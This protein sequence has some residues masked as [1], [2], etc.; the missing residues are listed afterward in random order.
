MTMKVKL[1]KFR[2]LILK[3]YK[4][5]AG[6]TAGMMGLYFLIYRKVY[7]LYYTVDKS[8]DTTRRL[9]L[10]FL[11]EPAE[12]A[13]KAFNDYFFIAFMS[14]L[15]TAKPDEAERLQTLFIE[16][17]TRQANALGPVGSLIQRRLQR[18]AEDFYIAWTRPDKDLFM[19][20]Q[21]SLIF[22]NMW[23]ALLIRAVAR[24]KLSLADLLSTKEEQEKLVECLITESDWSWTQQSLIQFQP[25][26]DLF[27]LGKRSWKDFTVSTASRDLGD[28]PMLEA[29]LHP[30]HQ[31]Q[32]FIQ[33]KLTEFDSFEAKNPVD[34]LYT[35]NHAAT[36]DE[37]SWRWGAQQF[38][39]YHSR[40]ST[41]GVEY[42]PASNLAAV[43]Q[44]KHYTSMHT[45]LG[46]V[47]Q[48][49]L[50]TTF[51]Q[52]PSKNALIV[53][54]PGPEVT[55][56][57]RALVGELEMKLITDNARRYTTVIKNVAIGV[58]HLK[59]VCLK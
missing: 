57:V 47:I 41:L 7:R 18:L 37:L 32:E 14:D 9:M 6:F 1:I 25:L 48:D 10:Q 40:L 26:F 23:G 53:G 52:T 16:F 5:V 27:S 55:S 58:R 43:P 46:W 3:M 13:M 28:P 31:S 49:N 17:Y 2:T 11:E 34:A 36:M 38:N 24:Y 20:H 44:L 59:E 4:V 30:P 22:W 50:R 42:Q 56:L 54:P 19:R 8:I 29:V 21:K 12:N 15:L 51:A 45:Q 35:D 39:M 33:R